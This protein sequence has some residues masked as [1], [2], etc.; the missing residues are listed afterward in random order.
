MET[1]IILDGDVRGRYIVED[2][3]SLAID[4][5]YPGEL[6]D[7]EH[8]FVGE[9]CDDAIEWLNNEIAEPNHHFFFEGSL[10]YQ[11]FHKGG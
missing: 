9:A 5:G 6:I 8:E 1:G 3:Q 10:F 4:H 11:T 7:I 2:I